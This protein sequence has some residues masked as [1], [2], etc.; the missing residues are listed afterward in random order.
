[1][2]IRIDR[3]DDNPANPPL[4]NIVCAGRSSSASRAGL[5]RYVKNCFGR[6]RIIWFSEAIYFRVITASQPLTSTSNDTIVQNKHGSHSWIRACLS[7]SL[8]RLDQ[9]IL[10]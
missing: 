8:F 2:Q 1:F 10:P 7:R 9:G 4:D 6:D 5:E 3:P